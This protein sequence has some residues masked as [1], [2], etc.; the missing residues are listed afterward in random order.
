MAICNTEFRS[1]AEEHEGVAKCD[2]DHNFAL[3][4]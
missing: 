2:E 4:D 3:H 1:A